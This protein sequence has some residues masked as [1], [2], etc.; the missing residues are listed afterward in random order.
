MAFYNYERRYSKIGYR[1]P[2]DFE[3]SMATIVKAA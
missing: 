1:S 3:R 2:M